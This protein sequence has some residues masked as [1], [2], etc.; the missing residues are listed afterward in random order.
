VVLSL[1][2]PALVVSQYLK[3]QLPSGHTRGSSTG[4]PAIPLE[5]R[6]AP[7]RPAWTWLPTFLDQVQ[8]RK[9]IADAISPGR[10]ISRQAHQLQHIQRPQGGF[11]GI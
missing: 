3:L 11:H 5:K 7:A 2:R 9:S 1:G 6:A 4:N 8:H 10:S